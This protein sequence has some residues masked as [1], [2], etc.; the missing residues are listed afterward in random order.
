MS[1]GLTRDNY[2]LKMGRPA[3]LIITLAF[4]CAAPVEFTA[5]GEHVVLTAEEG[6][7]LCAGSMRHMDEFVALLAD[8]FGIKPPTGD[9]RIHYHWMTN[10]EVD[11]R[12][13]Q[14]AAGCAL[15]SEV[16]ARYAPLNHELVHAVASSL[17]RPRPLFAEGLAVAYEGLGI[18]PIE[19]FGSSTNRD[20]RAL[21]VLSSEELVS[22]GGYLLA[23]SFTSFLINRHGIDSYL[24]V[25]AAIGLN[26]DINNI[27]RAFSE[28]FA[29]TF[30]E[31]VTAFEASTEGTVLV[32]SKIDAKLM[33]C[34]APEI[35]WDGKRLTVERILGCDQDD[36]V[37][38]RDNKVVAY[39]TIT[40]ADGGKYEL[41]MAGDAQESV[42]EQDISYGDIPVLGV[43]LYICDDKKN[44]MATWVGSTP[45]LGYLAS[46]RYSLRLHG[47][48]AET[49]M[50]GFTLTRVPDLP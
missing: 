13:G 48:A 32:H 17:G 45:R 26:A 49:S 27:D 42:A 37:G 43:S 40:I 12:C 31:S 44:W 47:P 21:A 29:E 24:S 1:S 16:Y 9:A 11:Q 30:E 18:G 15:G 50:L 19:F 23:G 10:A 2:A 46:G 4:G 22:I 41:R 34:S 35:E 36:A 39:H 8:E 28:A 38:P 5:E 14:Y 7:V 20:L 6:L 25:Y 3:A 33:E